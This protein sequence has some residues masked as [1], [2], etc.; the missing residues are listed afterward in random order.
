MRRTATTGGC[1]PAKPLPAQVF[2]P[3][4]G[5]RAHH[6]LL[7][8]WLAAPLQRLRRESATI[9]FS[10]IPTPLTQMIECSQVSNAF[11]G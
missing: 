11:K 6:D 1:D 2:D 9:A 8:H 5:E 4:L 7:T 3:L 10:L